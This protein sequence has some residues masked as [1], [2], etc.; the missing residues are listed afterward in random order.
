MTL[1]LATLN[2]ALDIVLK[3]LLLGVVVLLLV[4]LR[5]ARRALKSAEDSMKSA[6]DLLEKI[7]TYTSA[8]AIWGKLRGAKD[9]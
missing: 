1:D 7:D 8:R 3:L 4:I 6:E 9:E 5:D 2:L